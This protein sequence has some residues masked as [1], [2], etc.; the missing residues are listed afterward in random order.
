MMGLGEGFDVASRVLDTVIG[1]PGCGH[2]R[3]GC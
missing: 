2:E 1:M 3:R